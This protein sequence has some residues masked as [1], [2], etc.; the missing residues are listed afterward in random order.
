MLVTKPSEIPNNPHFQI[1]W[2]S[3]IQQWSGKEEDPLKYRMITGIEIVL[4]EEDLKKRL[5]EIG[6][7]GYQNYIV[8]EIK[9]LCSIEIKIVVNIT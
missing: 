8:Q 5:N 1:I 9:K 2:F 4:S 3:E 7:S 6:R